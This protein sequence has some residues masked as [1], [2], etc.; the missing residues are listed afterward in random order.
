MWTVLLILPLMASITNRPLLGLFSGR[1]ALTNPQV[2]LIRFK[3]DFANLKYLNKGDRFEMWD[4]RSGK[5]RCEGRVK[6]KTNDYLLVRIPN[7]QACEKASYLTEGAYFRFYSEDLVNNIKRGEEL[8]GVLMKKQLALSG[9]VQNIK[10][11]L[12]IYLEKVDALN[13]RYKVLRD[14]LEAEWRDQIQALEED[15]AE[16]LRK[17]QEYRVRLLDVEGKLER[18]RIEDQNLKEDRWAL[19]PRLYY[20]K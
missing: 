4:Q 16:D 11:N 10:K 20:F 17:Y 7:Y 3:V 1:V 8:I 15:K 19:D 6:G 2:G 9:K 12:D 5:S 13:L 18:Y 14:K